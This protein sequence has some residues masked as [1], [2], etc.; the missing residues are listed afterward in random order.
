MRIYTY[1]GHHIVIQSE[2]QTGGLTAAATIT[3]LLRSGTSEAKC[4]PLKSHHATAA[5]A[6]AA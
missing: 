6:V 2:E 3:R 5:E 4:V 1:Q